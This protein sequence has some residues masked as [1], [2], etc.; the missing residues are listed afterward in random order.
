MLKIYLLAGGTNNKDYRF[1][2][3]MLKTKLDE[4][5]LAIGYMDKA[6]A[7]AHP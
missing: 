3:R 6:Q 4:E 7:D 2:L 1:G 5:L